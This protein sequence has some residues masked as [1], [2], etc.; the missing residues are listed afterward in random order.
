MSR[1]GKEVIR[2]IIFA[3]IIIIVVFIPLFTLQGVEGKTFRPLAFTISLAM[4]GSLFF[5]VLIAPVIS[6][7]LM[8]RT[9][10]ELRKKEEKEI[11]IVRFLIKTYRPIV[12]FFVKRRTAAISLGVAILMIGAM[13]AKL[14]SLLLPTPFSCLKLAFG[15]ALSKKKKKN[16]SLDV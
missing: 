7:F 11:W 13:G 5:A 9:K 8:K 12:T 14:C 4:F 3:I 16:S 10:K 15:S 1:A 2:P 6:S